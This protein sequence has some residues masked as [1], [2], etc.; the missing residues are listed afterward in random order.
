MAFHAIAALDNCHYFSY[1]TPNLAH[2]GDVSGCDP[3]YGASAVPA[4]GLANLPR[5]ALGI[6]PPVIMA[7]RGCHWTG[8]GRGG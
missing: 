4:G 8:T 1:I 7:G 6:M 2:I 3:T 5:A